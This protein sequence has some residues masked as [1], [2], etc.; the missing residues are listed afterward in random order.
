MTDVTQPIRDAL[1]AFEAADGYREDKE[2]V[3]NF[4]DALTRTTVIA[5]LARLD[6]AESAYI[7]SVRLHNLTLDELD[8]ARY[9]WLRGQK[10][11]HPVI[12]IGVAGI[13]FKNRWALGAGDETKID[14][15]ID[16]AMKGKP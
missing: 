7:E 11:H 9:R 15:A 10:L 16:A 14:A 12:Y 1:A 2:A 6:A 8:A 3:C 5:L 13:D 4:H